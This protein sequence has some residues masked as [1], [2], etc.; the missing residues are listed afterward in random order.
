MNNCLILG[1]GR[2]GTSMLAGALR[3]AGY[4]MGEHLLSPSARNPKG[5][6]E[7]EEINRINE[8]LLAPVVPARPRGLLGTFYR[9]RPTRGQRWLAALRP[10]VRIVPTPTL[11]QR[12]AAQTVKRPFCFKDPRFSYTLTA[13]RPFL[14]GETVFACVFRDPAT[15]ASSMVKAC[16][17]IYGRRLRLSFGGA[18]RVWTSMYQHILAIHRHVGTWVFLHYD[19]IVTGAAFDQLEVVLGVRV[20]RTFPD[21]QLDRSQAVG[22]AGAEDRRV[23][24][25]LCALAGV[26]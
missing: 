15:T 9:H 4:Y 25:Q 8:E 13:W 21:R 23:Y 5:F 3:Q 19:Q 1:S 12:M 24:E 10:G 7:D 17:E 16:Q 6:F 20:D 18:L 2:S 22:D 26:R 11:A 14:D